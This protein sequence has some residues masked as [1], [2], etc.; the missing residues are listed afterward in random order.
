MVPVACT[1]AAGS[2]LLGAVKLRMFG[3]N[4]WLLVGV[5][6]LLVVGLAV[7]IAIWTGV[8]ILWWRASR[9]RAEQNMHRRHHLPDGTPLPP[10]SRG[11]CDRC[12]Q[13]ANPVYHTKDGRHLCLHHYQ[14]EKNQQQ[15]AKTTRTDNHRNDA[16]T[17]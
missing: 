16:A 13:V 15:A 12:Q 17:N 10:A 3:A 11:I 5:L 4:I 9:H 8:N 6:I 14:E 2:T 7:L 1:L